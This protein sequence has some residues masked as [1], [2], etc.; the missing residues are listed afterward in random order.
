[1][2]VLLGES[3]QQREEEGKK[4]EEK[5]EQEEEESASGWWWRRK[6]E[7]EKK[8][9]VKVV[10]MSMGA[11]SLLVRM[12]DLVDEDSASVAQTGSWF[13]HIL[14]R[15]GLGVELN[16]TLPSTG[17]TTHTHTFT[18]ASLF[19]MYCILPGEMRVLE[20]GV[21]Y[22]REGNGWLNTVYIY[23]TLN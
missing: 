15:K 14:F 1:M 7:E 3:E 23:Q 5:E 9:E 20:W 11:C 2:I 10:Q 13:K 16:V 21:S 12:S 18:P 4:E 8:E 19:G 6:K 22:T 17:Y